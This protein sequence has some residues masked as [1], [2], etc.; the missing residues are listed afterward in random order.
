ML[1]VTTPGALKTYYQGFRRL[2]QAFPN[3]WGTLAGLEEHMRAEEW[4]R[5]RQ[6]YAEG[7]TQPPSDY[8]PAKPWM[9]IIPSSRPFS[10]W[11]PGRTG[12]AS[13]YWFWNGAPKTT[14]QSP[15]TR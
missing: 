4:T 2:Y 12:G 8:N 11:V 1:D 13:A 10:P 7:I 3:L 6:E 14:R 9:S 5:I 15:V